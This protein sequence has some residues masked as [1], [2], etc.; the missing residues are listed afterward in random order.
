M[1]VVG[2]DAALVGRARL[3]VLE[4]DARLAADDVL[5]ALRAEEREELVR[6]G[7]ARAAREPRE[8]RPLARR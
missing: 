1:R 3:E 6:Q 4:V 8:A 5:E 2:A 7:R